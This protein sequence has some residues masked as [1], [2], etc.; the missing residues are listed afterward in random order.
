[1]Q[2]RRT[3]HNLRD[4]AL[5]Y[6]INIAP[7]KVELKVEA[8]KEQAVTALNYIHTW[9]RIQ[10]QIKARRLY[11]LTE[12]RIKQKKLENQL[13]LA[14]EIH[15]LQVYYYCHLDNVF[16]FQLLLTKVLNKPL[17]KS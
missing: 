3:L 7:W 13:K 14:A 10:E 4:T 16:S 11:M 8:A 17:S 12:A 2:A 6:T 5:N 1:M 9:S 15:R